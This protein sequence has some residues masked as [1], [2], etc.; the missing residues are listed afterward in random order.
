MCHLT[1]ALP[2]VVAKCLE[3]LDGVEDD[4]ATADAFPKKERISFPEP[5]DID[6]EVEA[7]LAEG[8]MASRDEER[9]QAAERVFRVSVAS[10]LARASALRCC[11]N[12]SK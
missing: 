4:E 1:F 5:C 11:N 12:R 6:F 2:P 7:W 8:D 10:R 9:K 3:V